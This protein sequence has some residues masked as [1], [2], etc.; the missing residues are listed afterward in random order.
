MR[1]TQACAGLV[2]AALLASCGKPSD[3][4]LDKRAEAASAL[5]A[6]IVKAQNAFGLSLHRQMVLED[7]GSNVFLSP[8]SVSMA[9]AMTYN[10]SAGDTKRVMAA[11]LGWTGM[12]AEEVNQGYKTVKAL[13]EKTGKGVELNVANSLWGRKGK[14]FHKAFLELNRSFYDAKVTELD[15]NNPK[16]H[17]TINSW[18]DKQTRNK[19][20]SILNKPLNPDDDLVLVNAIYFK[21]QWKDEF[22]PSSTKE[23]SFKLIDGTDKK[24]SM[25]SR[26]GTYEYLQEK[27]FQAIRLPYGEGQMSMLVILP[28]ES[29]SLSALH[30]L[31]WSDATRW[32]KPFERKVGEIRLPSF[33]LEYGKPLDKALQSMGMGLAYDPGKADF[34]GIASVPPNLYVGQVMH[35]TFLEV[36]E[37]GTEAAAATSVTMKTAS[38][39]VPK[40]PFLMNVNRPFFMAIEDSQTGAW[41]FAGSIYSP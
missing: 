18:V 5:D 40:A 16:A 11:T 17:E 29:S 36:N 21:G 25:M 12:S 35:K 8:T 30:D 28:D 24:V 1:V 10:G 3:I 9:L 31:L 15:F 26:T 41:L 38:A 4:S 13:L 22:A 20:P 23:E 2:L 34:S 7:K 14:P 33:K 19:I 27:G 39:E 6:R 32:Q 37:K